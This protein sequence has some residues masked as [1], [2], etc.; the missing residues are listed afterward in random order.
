M[1]KSL[2][3]AVVAL[4]SVQSWAQ[5]G[6][7]DVSFNPTDAGMGQGDGAYGKVSAVLPL[8]GGGALIAGSFLCHTCKPPCFLVMYS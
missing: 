5:A 4:W 1:F 8:P 7:V 3:F 2:L 6:A